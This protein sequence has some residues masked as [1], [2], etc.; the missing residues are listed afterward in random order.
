MDLSKTSERIK[1]MRKENNI[2]SQEALAE[3]I[4]CDRKT[5]TGWENGD[6]PNWTSILKLAK[7]FHCDPEY[8]LGCVDKP[9]VTTAWIAEQIPLSETSIEYLKWLKKASDDNTCEAPHLEVGMIDTIITALC[10]GID[11]G[12]NDVVWSAEELMNLLV[13]ANREDE[14]NPYINH[15]LFIKQAFCMALGSVAY[16][17]IAKL[18]SSDIQQRRAELEDTERYMRQEEERINRIRKRREEL[19]IS[20][21]D[22]VESVRRLRE[23]GLSLSDAIAFV[24]KAESSLL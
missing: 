11:D 8:L 10:K 18:A 7:A 5:V 6:I 9:K 14:R 15:S 21:N 19:G 24:L 20:E 3:M 23:K 2:K 13:Y 22:Y 16:D 12:V 4:G 1:E 17:Y